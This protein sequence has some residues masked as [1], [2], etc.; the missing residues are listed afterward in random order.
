[1]VRDMNGS[2]GLE[3]R[4]NVRLAGIRAEACWRIDEADA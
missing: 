4:E 3:G 1:M 2:P